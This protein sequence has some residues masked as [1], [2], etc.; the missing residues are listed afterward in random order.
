MKN[1]CFFQLKIRKLA[2]RTINI[3]L[4]EKDFF[5]ELFSMSLGATKTNGSHVTLYEKWVFFQ[6]KIRK[7]AIRTIDIN[8]M[9]KR[10]F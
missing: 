10:F 9:E 6:L 8:L 3:N 2:I 5:D 4:M 7:L 1:G